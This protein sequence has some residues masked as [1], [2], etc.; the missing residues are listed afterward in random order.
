MSPNSETMLMVVP[1]IHMKPMVASSATGMPADTQKATRAFKNTN[2][3]AT[4]MASPPRPFLTSRRMRS[5]S[6]SARIS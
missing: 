3:T 5:T 6:A 2:R 1:T 4:T